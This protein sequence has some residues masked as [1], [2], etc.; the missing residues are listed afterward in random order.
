MAL[1]AW[2]HNLKF[3]GSDA[4]AVFN[5]RTVTRTFII[6]VGAGDAFDIEVVRTGGSDDLMT[7]NMRSSISI[8]FHEGF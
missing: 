5:E 6:D 7:C 8:D 2:I 3:H 1:L 4:V